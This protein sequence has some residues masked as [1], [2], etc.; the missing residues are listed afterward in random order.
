MMLK[1]H[2]QCGHQADEHTDD[3]QCLITAC[4]CPGYAAALTDEAPI[5]T[6]GPVP[7]PDADDDDKA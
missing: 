4:P 5:P 3:G 7:D 2:C 6:D 1:S